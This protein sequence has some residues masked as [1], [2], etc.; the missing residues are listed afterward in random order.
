M[1]KKKQKKKSKNPLW[2]YFIPIFVGLFLSLIYVSYNLFWISSGKEATGIVMSV[3]ERQELQRNGIRETVYRYTIQ[4]TDQ[5]G[6]KKTGTY[7]TVVQKK[8]M[9]T[10][11]TCRILYSPTNSKYLELAAIHMSWGPILIF[12]AIGTF[13]S[14]YVSWKD[15][16]R[17]FI[18]V[19]TKR[20][21]QNKQ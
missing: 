16:K 9:N 17:F 4:Y 20:I 12:W 14:L 3:S 21:N 1:G 6:N 10:G 7:T 11:S 8:G 15:I 19:K 13:L 5:S 2:G 18:R